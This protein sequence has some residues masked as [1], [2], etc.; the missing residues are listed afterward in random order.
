MAPE[1]AD[2]TGTG[3]AFKAI[4]RARQGRC[5][6]GSAPCV[7]LGDDQTDSRLLRRLPRVRA[8]R[9]R[10]PAEPARVAVAESRR[11][12]AR[13]RGDQALAPGPAQRRLRAG[14]GRPGSALRADSS[15]DGVAHHGLVRAAAPDPACGLAVAAGSSM[16]TCHATFT[17]HVP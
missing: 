12:A 11:E 7:L 1:R 3:G 14:Q 6:K 2:Y 4:A 13:A 10:P 16:E 17:V 15:Q 5:H 9:A 8:R